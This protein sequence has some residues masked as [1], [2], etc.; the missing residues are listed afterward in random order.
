[1]VVRTLQEG[2]DTAWSAPS[3][4]AGAAEE[5]AGAAMGRIGNTALRQAG[6]VA[7]VVSTVRDSGIPTVLGEMLSPLR[8]GG[9]LST[10]MRKAAR[11]TTEIEVQTGDRD[12]AMVTLEPGDTVTTIAHDLT[13]N[14]HSGFSPV[15]VSTIRPTE[16]GGKETTSVP[17]DARFTD[18][19]N[20]P[21]N[22]RNVDVTSLGEY[23]HIRRILI[24][25][26]PE[27]A[28]ELR[29]AVVSPDSPQSLTSILRGE[30]ADNLHLLAAAFLLEDTLLATQIESLRAVAKASPRLGLFLAKVIDDDT[31][32]EGYARLTVA[33]PT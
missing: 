5:M 9:R 21:D 13:K 15:R 18:I 17:C 7:N 31:V 20:L 10:P 28:A 3:R 1:M 2:L 29:A 32:L 22:R 26:S 23:D 19:L 16:G 24:S 4:L 11:S 6:A 12:N 8:P 25:L 14:A 27:R 30:I 33:I